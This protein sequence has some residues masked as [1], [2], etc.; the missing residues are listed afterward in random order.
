M[1]SDLMALAAVLVLAFAQVGLASVVTLR[2][3]GPTW[4]LGPRDRPFDVPGVAGRLVRAHRNLLEILPQFV[5]ALLCVHA[6]DSVS[7]L[8]A[9]GAWTFFVARVVYIPAYASG[10]NWLRPL[11]W[12]AA[13]MGLMAVLVD[14]FL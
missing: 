10:V 3:A 9:W 13:T 7:E 11:C 4:V 8:S 12:Q 5:G 2:H 6:A 1:T 14:A